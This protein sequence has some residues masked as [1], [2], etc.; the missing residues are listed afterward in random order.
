LAAAY[1]Q[2]KDWAPLIALWELRVN[3]SSATAQT[4]FGLAAAQY[5]AGESAQAI[6]TLNKAVAL[7]PDASSSAAAAIAQINAGQ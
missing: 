7:Y 1:Y 5:V 2:G 3:E 6:A 4:W